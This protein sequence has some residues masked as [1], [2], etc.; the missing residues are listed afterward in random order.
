LAA[1]FNEVLNYTKNKINS[2]EIMNEWILEITPKTYFDY[3]N[4]NSICNYTNYEK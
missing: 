3:F 4:E 2:L 1:K